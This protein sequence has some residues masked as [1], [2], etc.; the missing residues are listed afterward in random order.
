MLDFMNIKP[1]K[2]TKTQKTSNAIHLTVITSSLP[3]EMELVVAIKPNPS[4]EARY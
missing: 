3:V 2:R 1:E 4:S